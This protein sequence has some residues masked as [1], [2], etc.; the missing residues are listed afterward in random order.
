MNVIVGVCTFV[1]GKEAAIKLV[2]RD[3][4]SH[5]YP[6]LSTE[7]ACRAILA[8]AFAFDNDI[9]AG[10]IGPAKTGI[11]KE[12]IE[13]NLR[14]VVSLYQ[15]PP[16]KRDVLYLQRN[17]EIKGA[18]PAQNEAYRHLLIER[19]VAIRR[20]Q[21]LAITEEIANVLGEFKEEYKVRIVGSDRRLMSGNPD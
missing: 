15:A 9:V 11:C 16:P 7:V 6:E 2:K 12:S 20:N 3:V 13:R 18:T 10:Y 4:T 5:A 8:R 1:L 17:S 14:S 19:E 21:K